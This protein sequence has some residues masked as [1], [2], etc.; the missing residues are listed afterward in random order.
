MNSS[1]SEYQVNCSLVV[2]VR[3]ACE[4]LLGHAASLGLPVNIFRPSMCANSERS[5]RGLERDDINRRV[6]VSSLHTGYVPDFGS[7]KGGGMSW[8]G[9]EWLVFSMVQL[10]G[11]STTSAVPNA[12]NAGPSGPVIYHMVPDTHI[13][14]SK[15]AQVLGGGFSG[16]PLRMAAPEE[17][18]TALTRS[19][20]AE[21][22]MHAE[23]L[24]SWRVGGKRDGSGLRL[25]V[26]ICGHCCATGMGI[27][28]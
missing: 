25:M 1:Q 21:M 22:A 4:R 15:I 2:K 23:V 18:F 27:G 17:W 14:Y 10:S 7:D 24:K 5:G 19:G 26:R 8:M 9:V 13:P 20:D 6:L 16:D 12:A 28:T 3:W 11:L